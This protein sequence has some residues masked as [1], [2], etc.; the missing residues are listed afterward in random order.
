MIRRSSPLGFPVRFIAAL[1][2][3]VQE[4]HWAHALM[5]TGLLASL[6]V[7]YEDPVLEWLDVAMLRIVPEFENSWVG[8]ILRTLGWSPSFSAMDPAKSLKV[9]VLTIEQPYFDKAFGG[10]A[11]I[12]RKEFLDLLNEAKTVFF[13]RDVP[14]GARVP[15]VLAIDYDLSPDPK[16]SS[17]ESERQRQLETFLERF[18]ASKGK[19]GERRTVLLIHHLDDF[20]EESCSRR[21]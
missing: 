18:A 20:D 11:P 2:R 3:L 8:P 6:T 12:P 5:A 10:R 13:D 17:E 19:D 7:L 21:M 14:D 9:L 4:Y 15:R 1:R 16:A